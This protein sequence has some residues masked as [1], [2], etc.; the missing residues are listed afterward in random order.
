VVV[1]GR[2]SLAQVRLYLKNL[3]VVFGRMEHL[4]QVF[5]L[6]KMLI[7]TD[8]PSE[9]VDVIYE[10]SLILEEGHA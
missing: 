6:N 2:W 5:T 7:S 1:V 10:S 9:V 4:Y 3:S 8:A